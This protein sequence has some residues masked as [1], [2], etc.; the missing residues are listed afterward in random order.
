M[1]TPGVLPLLCLIL[2]IPSL[3]GGVGEGVEVDADIPGVAVFLDNQYQGDT[4]LTLPGL[5]PGEYRV[6]AT[7]PGYHPQVRNVTVAEDGTGDVFFVFGEDPAEP[8]PGLVRIRDCV[9]TPEQ[10][11]LQGTAVSIVGRSDRDLMVY[12]SGVGDGIR[13]AGSEAGE[14]WH[15]YPEGCLEVPDGDASRLVSRPW[16]FPAADGGYRMVYLSGDRKGPSLLSAYSADG[17]QFTPE[18]EVTITRSTGTGGGWYDTGSIPTGIRLTDGSLRMYYSPLQGGVK[19]AVSRDD[20]KTWAEEEGYRLVAAA[21]PSVTILPDGRVGLFYVD[22]STG[23][24]G[25]KL[26]V[27][28]SDDGLVFTPDESGTLIETDQK[29]VW[30]LDPDIHPSGDGMWILLYSVMGSAGEAGITVPTVMQSV[31][32]SDCLASRI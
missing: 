23:K 26:M 29:G 5:D 20:G 10:T 7:A 8:H 27:A 25:Q 9:G 32:D 22:L 21:D 15:E 1:K 12:Y 13:C 30:I 11:G 16:V 18:G 14:R 19:S 6:G 28:P 31:I 4:P 3:A 2:F 17:V 24:K